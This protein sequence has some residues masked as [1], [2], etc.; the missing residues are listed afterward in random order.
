VA[1]R[2]V[3]LPP[4]AQERPCPTPS[5][6]REPCDSAAMPPRVESLLRT[7][8]RHQTESFCC[9]CDSRGSRVRVMRISSMG[10]RRGLLRAR[11]LL[12]CRVFERRPEI[13]LGPIDLRNKYRKFRQWQRVAKTSITTLRLKSFRRQ[14]VR[15][16]PR[17]IA[18]LTRRPTPFGLRSKNY[19][20]NSWSEHTWRSKK[21][22]STVREYADSTSMRTTLLRDKLAVSLD[23][24]EEWNLPSLASK[25]IKRP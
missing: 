9:E 17:D 6:S 13:V 11:R 4:Q 20:R 8:Y 16:D 10:S 18:A 3:A 5:N 23:D 22:D 24:V 25:G 1:E 19:R 12:P 21:K 2:P 14:R 7:P 15:D